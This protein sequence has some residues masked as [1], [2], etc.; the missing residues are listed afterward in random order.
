MRLKTLIYSLFLS[1]MF[2]ACVEVDTPIPTFQPNG[3]RK[4]LLEEISGANCAPCADAAREI[5]NLQA[6]YGENL[7]VVTMHTFLATPQAR[8]VADATYDFRTI[9]GTEIL[10]FIGV[11][12]G[13][14]TGSVNRELF[15][16]ETDRLLGKNQ[17]PG[18]I[19]EEINRPPEV[20]LN[21]ET[22]LETINRVVNIDVTIVPNQ[23]L[24]GDLR[25]TVVLTEDNISDK[26]LSSTGVID[27]FKHSHIMRSV[28]TPFDGMSLG[29]SLVSGK[30]LTESFRVSIP[31]ADSGGPWDL[32]QLNVVA[33]V[34]LNDLSKGDRR[35]LQAD[36]NKIAQ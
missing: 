22:S 4:V 2:L 19:A 11:P 5:A 31:T 17:W 32:N 14:P 18:F 10:D 21:I 28:V 13:I 6:L 33:Y 26:Q 7:V 35:I 9:E 36:E 12:I 8:P 1:T 23:D 3:E 25:L 20:G 24:E 29:N 34:S 15:E 16:N 30:A 27:D